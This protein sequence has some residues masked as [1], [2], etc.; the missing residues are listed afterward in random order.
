MLYLSSMARR[1]GPCIG[2]GR[3]KC[4]KE[5][6]E[7]LSQMV[8]DMFK[9]LWER[10]REFD[11]VLQMAEDNRETLDRVMDDVHTVRER[12]NAVRLKTLR[13]SE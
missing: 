8:D 5:S 10:M 3:I 4:G 2:C 12:V 9:A 11:L 13:S 1:N 7:C 6:V